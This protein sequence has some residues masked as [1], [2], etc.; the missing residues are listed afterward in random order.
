MFLLSFALS[1]FTS[2]VAEKSPDRFYAWP[3]ALSHLKRKGGYVG[4]LIDVYIIRNVVILY[5]NT[6]TK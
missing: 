4:F 1:V 6:K 5:A 2:H 3:D